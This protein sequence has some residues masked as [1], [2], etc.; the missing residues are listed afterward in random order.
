MRREAA[1]DW[2][3]K[4]AIKLVKAQSGITLTVRQLQAWDQRRAVVASRRGPNKKR[5]YD[6]LGVRQLC[7]VARLI[8]AGLPPNRIRSAIQGVEGAAAR[9][10]KRWD[11]LRIA[12]DGASVFVIDGDKGINA[13]DGQI[14]NLVLLGELDKKTKRICQEDRARRKVG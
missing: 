1:D 9:I 12:T 8:D 10:G 4:R 3:T 11:E 14:V 13:V 6:F 2:D 7:I 5:F